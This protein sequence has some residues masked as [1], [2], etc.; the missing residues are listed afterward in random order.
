[1]I[2]ESDEEKKKTRLLDAKAPANRNPKRKNP[3]R[4]QSRKGKRLLQNG[5][6]PKRLNPT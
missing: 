2:V 3:Q 6:T 5:R 4:N 1:V